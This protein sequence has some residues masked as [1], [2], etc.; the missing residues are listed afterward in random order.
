MALRVVVCFV[1]FSLPAFFVRAQESAPRTRISVFFP[2]NRY[3]LLKDYANN[4]EALE[5]LDRHLDESNPAAINL[6]VIISAAS[7]EGPVARNMVLSQRRGEALRSYILA[8]RPDLEDKIE[9]RPVGEAWTELSII[10]ESLPLSERKKALRSHPNWRQIVNK[11]LPPLRYA[12]LELTRE[13]LSS[14][15]LE[16]PLFP[17]PQQT[18]QVP[19][20]ITETTKLPSSRPVI[21]VSTNLLYDLTYIP[22][23]GLT[24]IPSFSLEYY[25]SRGHYTVGADV[26]WPMWRHYEDHR[27]M[28]VNNL[29]FWVRRYFRATDGRFR[30]G[31]LFASAN[32]ARYGIGWEAKGWEGEGLGASLGAGW[33]FLLGRRL[34]LDMGA[35]V[36]GFYSAYD[37]YVYGFDATGRYY[38]DFAGDESQ[39]TPRRKRL[40]WFGPTRVYISLGVD[41]FNRKKK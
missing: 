9:L 12:R 24:S 10:D 27:F 30:G 36:G 23:Y 41:L 32:A 16:N 40:M 33:K 6:V 28:Q 21:G 11:K 31:Y 4:A 29:T 35:A 5:V 17:V 22:H 14:F 2:V 26:E 34:F 13:S 8:Q 19:Q 20:L 38:Y 18:L 15:T 39:F 25:P 7:P 3:V 1:F 37:P